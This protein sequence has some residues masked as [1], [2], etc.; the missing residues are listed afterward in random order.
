MNNYISCLNEKNYDDYFQCIREYINSKNSFEGASYFIKIGPKTEAIDKNLI[1]PTIYGYILEYYNL[2][3]DSH[4]IVSLRKR[5]ATGADTIEYITNIGN[6]RDDIYFDNSRTKLPES[7]SLRNSEDGKEIK[8]LIEVRPY[9]F[10]TMEDIEKLKR[11]LDMKFA[12][13]FYIPLSLSLI[14]LINNPKYFPNIYYISRP[15]TCTK[16]NSEISYAFEITYRT[17]GTIKRPIKL[18]NDNLC[19]LSIIEFINSPTME[20]YSLN[21]NPLFELKKENL[22]KFEIQIKYDEFEFRIY[23]SIIE[24]IKAISELMFS[25]DDIGTYQIVIKDNKPIFIDFASGIQL[26]INQ[27]GLDRI[28]LEVIGDITESVYDS[29]L[30][31]HCAINDKYV[32]CNEKIKK[33]DLPEKLTKNLNLDNILNYT[34]ENIS[35]RKI[36]KLIKSTKIGNIELSDIIIQHRNDEFEENREIA[37]KAIELYLKSYN[38]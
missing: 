30:L 13:N 10:K 14:L 23:N 37:S 33:S 4:L 7:I 27:K 16:K 26:P 38:N 3:E 32:I 11:S 5:T 36:D 29:P 20:P 8:K 6:R 19:F 22:N 34:Y 24:V 17:F 18:F 2:P 15:Y 31:N 9:R 21:L 28:I 25:P 35:G 1:F 12:D